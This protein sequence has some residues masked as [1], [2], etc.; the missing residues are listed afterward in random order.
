VQGIVESVLRKGEFIVDQIE[1]NFLLGRC[2]GEGTV[3]TEC[4]SN[5]EDDSCVNDT[6]AVHSSK[7][8]SIS[9][10]NEGGSCHFVLVSGLPG[11]GK[12]SL[13]RTAL[14]KSRSAENKSFILVSERFQTPKA[15]G[16]AFKENFSKRLNK[17]RPFKALPAIQEIFRIAS[18]STELSR[19]VQSVIKELL[20]N[21]DDMNAL[22]ELLPGLRK[23]LQDDADALES[24]NL[25]ESSDVPSTEPGIQ[26]DLHLTG[27]SI[28]ILQKFVLAV[29]TFVPIVVLL[30][31]V[32]HAD[33]TSLLLIK[34]LLATN[35]T[36]TELQPADSSKGLIIFATYSDVDGVLSSSSLLSSF[37]SADGNSAKPL[38]PTEMTNECASKPPVSGPPSHSTDFIHQIAVTDLSWDDVSEWVHACGGYI[39]KCSA[40]QKT[41]ITNLVF[42]HSNG[43]PLH[44]R[45]L[46]L[47]LEEAE[48]L[49]QEPIHK[50]R[51]PCKLDDL[52]TSVLLRQEKS[53]QKVVQVTAFLALYCEGDVSHEVIDTA[54]N[55]PCI[56]IIEAAN[57]L[58]LLECSSTRPSSYFSR[59]SFQ[60][61]S[62][63]TITD[64]SSLYLDIGR[65]IW[66]NAILFQDLK[67]ESD[68]DVIAR[69][70]LSTQLLR[71]CIDLLRDIDERIYMSQLCYETGQKSSS[72]GDFQ[73]SSKLFEFAICVLGSELWRHDLYEASLVLHNSAA[74]SYCSIADYDKMQ[75]T[76]DVIFDRALTFQDQLAGY[77]VL[78]YAYASQNKLLDL[79]RTAS[80]VLHEI[81]EPIDSNPGSIS[82]VVNLLRTKWALRGKSDRFFSELPIVENAEYFI[83][84]QL[85]SLAMYH[86]YIFKPNAG[87]VLCFRLV[88]LSIKYGLTGPSLHAFTCYAFFLCTTGKFDEGYRMG[89][90]AL[91]YATKCGAWWP[92]INVLVYGCVNP[93]S[94]PFRHSLQPL[95]HARQAALAYG[96]LDM[97]ASASFYYLATSM[98]VG[99]PLLKLKTAAQ[100]F[101]LDIAASGQMTPLLSILPLWSVITGLLGEEETLDLG[102]EVNDAS[103]ALKHCIKEGN[104]FMTGNF[105]VNQTMWCCL[106]GD[107][108]EALQM[109][110][111]SF[112]QRQICDYTLTFYE[113]LAALAYSWNSTSF[114]NRISLRRGKKLA[115]FVKSWA[116]R[117]PENFRNKQWLLEAEIAALKGKTDHA[118]SL[119]EQS[120]GKAKSET[121]I[122]EEAI[123]FER[124][125]HYQR[126][127]GNVSDAKISFASAQMAYEKWGASILV[128]RMGDVLSSFHSK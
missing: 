53:M 91:K 110:K 82:V 63:S 114:L 39:Q 90:L 57:E 93:W 2:D 117:C 23:W 94:R 126:Y 34:S 92:R 50:K 86:S 14:D 28:P 106:I 60:K 29:V 77:V 31:D 26:F 111:T 13:V 67:R 99:M 49:L 96:D 97:H 11:S 100:V 84:T 16:A 88:R 118:L 30:E 73:T 83:L 51:I 98:S 116:D 76:V 48:S 70:L 75:K 21:P 125:G 121:F 85:L 27:D 105:Y 72:L 122:H 56:G 18:Q 41:E 46:L 38:A 62:C 108:E 59:E 42:H 120:I 1:N 19:A 5:S 79:F 64:V 33:E 81:G 69:V 123:A 54:L 112:E 37:K 43:N 128:E 3:P 24:T 66:R 12:R 35:E 71:N 101:C 7:E 10:G 15:I 113:G 80:M 52:F 87:L 4:T 44:I 9:I 58:G 61:A 127:I 17:N 6:T 89:Q 36:D 104:K 32:Q 65:S 74:Q 78:L 25:P 8:S 103:S 55:A 45:Y 115:K 95:N 109:A 22:C 107:Y 47:F 119:F 102:G 20:P 124:L 68:E 40:K